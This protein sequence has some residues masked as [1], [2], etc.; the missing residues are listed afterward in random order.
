MFVCIQRNYQKREKGP[1]FSD[2]LKIIE[3]F[4]FT[5]LP[6]F[7]GGVMVGSRAIERASK[8]EGKVFDRVPM[9]RMRGFKNAFN[10]YI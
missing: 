6:E 9:V 7:G 3:H 1:D 8:F 2:S 10:K 4:P 5:A